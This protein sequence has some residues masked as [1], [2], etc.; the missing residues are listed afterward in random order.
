MR[1]KS[2]KKALR[3]SKKREARNKKVRGA[4]KEAIKNF[5]KNPKEK[6]LSKV[7]SIIDTAAKK[8]IIHKNKAARLKSRLA[9]LLNKKKKEAPEPSKKKTI[10][11]RRSSN[12]K[13]SSKE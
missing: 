6:D 4:L 7:Y 3:Q 5:R 10:K 1:T 11:K 9:K 2:A 8:H 13:I 12:K